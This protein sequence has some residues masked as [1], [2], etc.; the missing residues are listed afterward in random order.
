[1]AAS[2]SCACGDPETTVY[3]FQGNY[4]NKDREKNYNPQEKN[5][6]SLSVTDRPREDDNLCICW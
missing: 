3:S 4:W 6:F 1:M 2:L 5:S